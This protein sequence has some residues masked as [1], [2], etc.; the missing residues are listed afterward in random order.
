MLKRA[1]QHSWVTGSLCVVLFWA[2]CGFA[3]GVQQDVAPSSVKKNQNDFR[4]SEK[5]NNFTRGELLEKFNAGEEDDYTLGRGDEITIEVWDH[6]DLSGKQTIGP[7]GR[8][9]LSQLGA[10]VVS[11]L[12]RDGAARAIG[13]KYSGFYIS[14]V[15]TVRVD[16]YTSNHVF[17]LGR[18]MKPGALD[19]ETT[20]TLLEAITRAGGL[21]V[22]GAGA[23]K[24]ALGRCAIFRGRDK[25]V[26]IELKE[27][28]KGNDLA[29]NIR[30]RRNDTVYI[31]DS[32]DQLVYV[33][34]EVHSPGAFRLTPNMTVLDALAL[35]GGPT[36]DSG[37]KYHVIRPSQKLEREVSLDDLL[38]P[39]PEVNFSMSEGDIVYIPR[40]GL[41]TLGY[42]LE[43][44]SPFTSLM[45]FGATFGNGFGGAKTTK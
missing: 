19:F 27:L 35:A 32:D 34:G 41:A 13:E 29:L 10:L 21:P 8:I 3:V 26:W 39:R 4:P 7:D 20:P 18:V 2:Q 5:T 14:P 23:E 30:L 31:P 36:R 22:G 9:T 28:L 42:V 24:A 33:L 38:K 16:R 1:N 43:K 44:L 11:G 37:K 17:V 25:I 40:R 12:T 45:L 15:V 6:P